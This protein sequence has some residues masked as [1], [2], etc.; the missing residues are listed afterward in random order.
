MPITQIQNIISDEML[1]SHTDA[2]TSSPTAEK[3]QVEHVEQKNQKPTEVLNDTL[4]NQEIQDAVNK[5]N[6]T[7][8]IF[9]KRLQ[10]SFHEEAKRI[11]VKIIDKENDKVIREIP[12]KEL[13]SFITRLHESLGVLVD[14]KR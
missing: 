13:L 4:Y 7:I 14:K 5:M 3:S 8:Q 12:P 2:V 1:K 11:V 10:F 6:K 9:N